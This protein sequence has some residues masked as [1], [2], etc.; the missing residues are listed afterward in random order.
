MTDIVVHSNNLPVKLEDLAK[1]V[2]VGREKLAAVRALIRAMD[3]IETAAG[4]REQKIEE[5]QML[6]EALLDA[7]ARIG[8]LTNEIPKASGGNHGNQYTGG[9]SNNTVTFAKTKEDIIKDLGFDRMQ[10]SRFETLAANKDIIEEAKAEARANDDIVNRTMVLK[11]IKE[12]EQVKNRFN[13]AIIKANES[14]V[15]ETVQQG[16]DLLA[17]V[18]EVKHGDI[19]LINGKHKLI[20]GDC[21]DVQEVL[22]IT[23]KVDAIITDPPYGI[24]YKSPTGSGKT[25]RGDYNVINNDDKEFDPAIL[26][27]YSTNVVTWGANYYA[28]KLP[29][30]AG[31]L[32]WDK[33]DG[34]AINNNSDCELAWSNMLGSARLFHHKWNGMIKASEKK[35]QRLHPTQKPVKLFIWCY[36]VTQSKQYIID[37]FGGSGTSLIACEQTGRT[38]YLV[39]NDVS[40]AA[41][42]LQR[43]QDSKYIIE[44]L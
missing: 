22:K 34:D 44:K 4:V 16:N 43:F 11:A 38:C 8:E 13:E 5:A 19:Y 12:K 1:F 36:E 9:K 2:L 30:S 37:P 27:K 21:S 14:D 32:V 20:V 7:E 26:F 6:A 39:E 33:R 35:E 41:A 25:K 23:G 15:V 17:K 31:W 24:G 10:V 40:F 3:R 29:P 28:H 42:A 18:K